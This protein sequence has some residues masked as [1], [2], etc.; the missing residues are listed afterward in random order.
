MADDVRRPQRLHVLYGLYARMDLIWLLRGGPQAITWLFAD[1]ILGLG[2]VATSFV[3]ASRF[4]GIGPWSYHEV[5]F[6]LGYALVSRGALDVFFDWNVA[7][8]SRRI[9]RGQLDHSLL[10]P[11]PLWKSLLAE[12]FAPFSSTATTLAGV[13]LL[14][15]ASSRLQIDRDAV[16]WGWLLVSLFSSTTV[17]VAF[18]YI[19]GALAFWAP[20]AAEEINS[21]TIRFVSQLGSFPLDGLGSVML[22]T[23]LTLVPVGFVAWLP[24]RALVAKET[25]AAAL[26]ATP[27]AALLFSATAVVIF[28]TGLAHYGRTGSTR[29]LALGHRR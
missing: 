25:A 18:T 22:G 27:L 28:R 4:D 23:L 3:L 6:L 15:F 21:D 2:M 24:C 17:I 9:G 10:Q 16:W 13:G 19:W 7:A 12:G 29:Y 11:Q 5:L 20:R 1:V 8:I 14:V 26:V